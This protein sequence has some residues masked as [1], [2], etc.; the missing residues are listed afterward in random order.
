MNEIDE[1]KFP[2]GYVPGHLKERV[3]NWRSISVGERIR[4]TSE[5][6]ADKQ[7]RLH[8]KA[9]RRTGAPIRRQEHRSQF[10]CRQSNRFHPGSGNNS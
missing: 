5:F 10:G 8:K 6:F 4:L 1:S 3:K 9:P 2:Y 7:A